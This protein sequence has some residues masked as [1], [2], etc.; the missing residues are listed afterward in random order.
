MK[1][2]ITTLTILVFLLIGSIGY[3]QKTVAVLSPNDKSNTGFGD[4]IREMLSTGIA[5]SEDLKPLGNALTDKA[6]K[7]S[8][9]QIVEVGD[10]DKITKLGRKIGADMVCVSM[11]QKVGSNFFITAKLI[12]T[13]TAS[14]EFQEYLQT[15]KGEDDLFEKV[16]E[17]AKMLTKLEVNITANIQAASDD[18]KIV[19]ID[20]I[21]YM[22]MPKDFDNKMDYKTAKE[23]CSDMIAYGYDDWFLPTKEQLNGLYLNREKLSGL[24][25][26]MYWSVTSVGGQANAQEIDSGDQQNVPKS[27]ELNVRCIKAVYGKIPSNL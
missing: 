8:N 23:A 15:N 11:I 3:A 5:K 14:V 1:N 24:R 27:S 2:T 16:D 25:P 17:I 19:E 7:E 10:D 20:F 26:E 9:Y 4:V 18:L 6:L 22:V 12:N 21:K 13:K